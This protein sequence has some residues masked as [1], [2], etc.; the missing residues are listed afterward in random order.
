M[1]QYCLS[2]GTLELVGDARAAWNLEAPGGNRC[3]MALYFAR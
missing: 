3:H 1:S 2:L